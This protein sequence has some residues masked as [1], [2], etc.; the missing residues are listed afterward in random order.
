MANGDQYVYLFD[1]VADFTYLGY[2]ANDDGEL[3]TGNPVPGTTLVGQQLVR[4][5]GGRVEWWKS[6]MVESG[7]VE[8]WKSG[9]VPPTIPPF[10]YSTIQPFH[11]STLPP[12]HYERR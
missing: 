4:L 8:E 1:G 9:K 3:G 2:I 10:H 5:K 11:F 7:K 6:G 12:F